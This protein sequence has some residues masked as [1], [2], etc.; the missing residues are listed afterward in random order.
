MKKIILITTAL[1]TFLLNGC[2]DY[3]DG[4]KTRFPDFVNNSNDTLYVHVN[5]TTYPDTATYMFNAHE[6][7]KLDDIYQRVAPKKRHATYAINTYDLED[8]DTVMIYVYCD[9]IFDNHSLLDI[10]KNHIVLARYD[11]SLEDFITLDHK[12]PYP[13]TEEMSEMKIYIP[14]K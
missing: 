12:I 6:P 13:P 4:Y 7:R 10:Y 3:G 5:K 11:L 8:S 1:L 2:V 9:T 14:N